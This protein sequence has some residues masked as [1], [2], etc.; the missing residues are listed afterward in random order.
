MHNLIA[1]ETSLLYLPASVI[2]VVVELH[3]CV[4]QTYTEAAKERAAGAADY[5]TQKLQDIKLG[6]VGEDGAVRCHGICMPV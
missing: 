4:E 6:L 3:V 2:N 5:T 1:A